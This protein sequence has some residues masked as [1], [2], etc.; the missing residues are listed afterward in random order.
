[1]VWLNYTG[2]SG[3]SGWTWGDG[4]AGSYTN[5]APSMPDDGGC[6]Y[7]DV[8][9]SG[10]SWPDGTWDDTSCSGGE[11]AILCAGR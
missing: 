7:M 3:P 8:D 9:G 11:R 1:M 10:G 2:G 6:A 5:W 4:Y